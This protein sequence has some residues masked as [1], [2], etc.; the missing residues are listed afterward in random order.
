MAFAKAEEILS[1]P[2]TDSMFLDARA[3]AANLKTL[4]DELGETTR[5]AQSFLSKA[6]STFARLGR[7]TAQ[8]EAGEGAIGR[9][10]NDSILVYRA[11]DVLIQLSV[12]L[13]DLRANP[14][15]YVRISIF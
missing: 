10:M 8:V 6:D 4:S 15:R 11:Q 5:D 2:T 1:S 3:T 7:L 12:L 14:Q 9:L 13:E